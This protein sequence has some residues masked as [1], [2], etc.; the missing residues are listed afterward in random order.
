MKPARRCLTFEA[1]PVRGVGVDRQTGPVTHAQ[2]QTDTAELV[3]VRASLLTALLPGGRIVPEHHRRAMLGPTEHLVDSGWTPATYTRLAALAAH[4]IR[5]DAW[6]S[7][8]GNLLMLGREPREW[9][10][11]RDVFRLAEFSTAQGAS[12]EAALGWLEVLAGAVNDEAAELARAA[13]AGW[14]AHY[15]PLHPGTW[16]IPDRLAGLAYA[17]GLTPVEMKQR[18]HAGTLEVEGLRLLAGLQGYRLP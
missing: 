14:G 16:D 5:V 6:V 18:Q 3:D 7:R 17:A 13:L 15:A 11:T 2:A 9:D 10:T 12:L 1:V 4:A 8:G